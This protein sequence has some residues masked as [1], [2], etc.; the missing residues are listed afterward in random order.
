MIPALLR[1]RANAVQGK[2]PEIRGPA[3]QW[4][5]IMHRVVEQNEPLRTVAA[6][7]DV[8]HEMIRRI[9]LHVQK[10]GGQQEA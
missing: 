9:V 4:P 8:F 6:D 7:Y 3:E 5:I 1:W 10:Q 2:T